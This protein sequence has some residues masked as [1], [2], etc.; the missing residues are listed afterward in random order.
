LTLAE[1]AG[2]RVPTLPWEQGGKAM[3]LVERPWRKRRLQ[4]FAVEPA[5]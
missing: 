5:G 3:E 1:F 2:L 4:S